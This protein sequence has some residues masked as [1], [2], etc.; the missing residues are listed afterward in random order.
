MIFAYG[1]LAND[2]K[3]MFEDAPKRPDAESQGV[4]SST[5]APLPSSVAAGK[6]PAYLEPPIRA[7]GART[8]PTEVVAGPKR[9]KRRTYM[10]RGEKEQ[11]KQSIEASINISPGSLYTR[12]AL[13]TNSLALDWGDDPNRR[14]TAIKKAVM[15]LKSKTPEELEATE[16]LLTQ[17]LEEADFFDIQSS[18]REVRRSGEIAAQGTSFAP[19]GEEISNVAVIIPT[20]TRFIDQSVREYIDVEEER[21]TV[22]S[23]DLEDGGARLSTISRS[24]FSET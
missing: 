7:A 24:I 12:N 22:L 11:K 14:R 4:Y 23:E 2:Q 17:L 15:S 10:T 1:P 5:A 16:L 8:A 6:G 9:R 20:Q 19:A 3:A 21:R 18:A 13:S